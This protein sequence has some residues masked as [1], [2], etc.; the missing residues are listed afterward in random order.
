MA[1]ALG[2]ITSTCKG[3]VDLVDNPICAMVLA[4]VQFT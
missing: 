1:L 3:A 2:L 4:I